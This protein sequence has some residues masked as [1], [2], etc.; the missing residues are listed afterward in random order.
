MKYTTAYKSEFMVMDCPYCNNRIYLDIQ[1]DM[2]EGNIP[3]NGRKIRCDN[4]DCL[5]VFLL[6]QDW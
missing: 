2:G 5:K 1:D 4:K 6:I 3:E